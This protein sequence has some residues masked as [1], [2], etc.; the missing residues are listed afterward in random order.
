MF[1]AALVLF[2]AAIVAVDQLTK[3]LA[4]ANLA[5]RTITLIPG[6]LQLHYITN[7]GMALSLLR[8]ARWL[9]VVMTVVYLAIVI[10]VVAKKWL[11]KKPELWCVAAITGGAIGNLIDRISS[12]LVIDMICIPWFSTFNVADLFI[13]FGALILVVYIFVKDKEL[14]ADKPKAQPEENRHGPDA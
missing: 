2:T 8:G 14:L 10:L 9:F 4:A 7:D 13:T 6:W 11:K 12:G 5:G 1:Y 3:Y